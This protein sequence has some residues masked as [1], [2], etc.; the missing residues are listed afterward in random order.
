MNNKFDIQKA[1]KED[2]LQV[3]ALQKSKLLKSKSTSENKSLSKEGFLVYELSVEDFS[4]ALRCKNTFL[5]V[6]KSKEKVIGY[7]LAYT[8]KKYTKLHPEFLKEIKLTKEGTLD[9]QNIIF[10]KQLVSD[11]SFPK[12]GESLNK[13]LF[14]IA[15]EKEYSLYVCEI[16]EGPLENKR[17]IEKHKSINLKRIGEHKDKK[18]YLW[19]IYSKKL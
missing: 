12:I 7:F 16:L 15:R 14:K 10:G 9:N 11:R 6:A 13:E 2:I 17:S 18:K 1:K 5:L 3:Y 19:G 4:K 8:L